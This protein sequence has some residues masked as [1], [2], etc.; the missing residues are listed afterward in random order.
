MLK[1]DPLSEIFT[2]LFFLICDLFSKS[3]S[4]S[5]LLKHLKWRENVW[6]AEQPN[7]GLQAALTWPHITHRAY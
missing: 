3:A 4:Q 5:S 6:P 1:F 7:E 2:L